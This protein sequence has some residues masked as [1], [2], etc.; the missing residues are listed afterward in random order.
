MLSVMYVKSKTTRTKQ[1]YIETRKATGITFATKE[2]SGFIRK[3]P[4][5]YILTWQQ[6][7]HKNRAVITPC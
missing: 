3:R 5:K 6:Q 7:I 1:T 4:K 2:S